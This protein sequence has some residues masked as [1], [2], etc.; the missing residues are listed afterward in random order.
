M[1]PQVTLQYSLWDQWKEVTSTEPRR[2]LCLASFVGRLLAGFT[3]PLSALKP[4]DFDAAG[5]WTARE[6]FL[7]RHTLRATL[8]S[9]AADSDADAAFTRLAGQAALGSLARGLGSFL[10]LRLGPWLV[11]QADAGLIPG[12]ELDICLRRLA[13]AE[14]T[15]LNS[16]AAVLATTA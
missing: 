13:H 12:Q 1:P 14:R 16:A 15:L 5:S 10:K 8:E 6:T 11:A 3:L 7:W 9:F 4:V 2:L